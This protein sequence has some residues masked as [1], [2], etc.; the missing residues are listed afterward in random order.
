MFAKQ[1]KNLEEKES[2]PKTASCLAEG[3]LTLDMHTS[4]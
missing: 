1:E 3:I 4:V 2:M